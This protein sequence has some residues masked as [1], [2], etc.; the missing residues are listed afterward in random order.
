LFIKIN[1]VNLIRFI[2]KL[3]GKYLAI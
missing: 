3:K 1:Q 2:S